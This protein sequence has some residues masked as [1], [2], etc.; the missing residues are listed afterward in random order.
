LTWHNR[1]QQLNRTITQPQPAKFHFIMTFRGFLSGGAI[2]VALAF[3]VTLPS[4]AAN[5]VNRYSFT[6]NA[7]DAVGGAHGTLLGGATVTGGALVLNGSGA[8]VDLPDGLLSTM[9][10]ATIEIWLTDNGSGTWSRIFDFGNGTSQY[11]F[12]SPQSGGGNLRSAITTTGS[13]QQVNWIGNRLPNGVPT[14]VAWT[15][16]AGTQTA[17]LYV[18]GALVGENLAHSLRPLD[19]GVTVN[20]WI[21]RSQF[22]ADPYLNAAINEFRIY[23]GAMTAAEISASNGSGPDNVP[24]GAVAFGLQPQSQTVP[25]LT[26]VEFTATF[27]GSP[28]VGMQWR[29]NGVNLPA[30]TNSALTVFAALTNQNA[31]YSL[32]LTNSHLGAPY[33]V[34]SSNA[35]LS[36]TPDTTSPT[37]IRAGSKF[38]NEVLV[39]FSEA[40]SPA[41]GTNTANYNLTR[42]GGSLAVAGAR[43]GDSTMEIILTTAP[44]TSGT[45]YT[46]TVNGVRDRSAAANLIAANSQANFIATPFLAV[47]VGTPAVGA[48]MIPVSG[49]YNLT[50][51]GTGIGGTNDQFTFAFADYTNNFDVRVRVASV[52]FASSWTRMGLMARAGLTTNAPYAASFATLGAAAS[53]FSARTTTGGSATINGSFP[54]NYPETWLRLRRTGSVFDGFASLDGQSW[55]YLGSA[56][57]AMPSIA[58]V[59]FA[60]T[61]GNATGATSTEIRDFANASG[62]ITTNAALAFEPLGPSSRRTALI[63]SEIMYNPPENWPGGDDL[64]F[65]ELWNSGLVTEDLTGHQLT[66]EIS[67]QF[68]D[69]TTIA[70][71]Q[72]LVVAKDPAAA[73]AF[74]GVNFLGPYAQR[75]SNTGGELFLLNEL[76]G[77]L[78]GIEYDTEA[79]WPVAPDGTGHSLVLSRPSYGENDPR[80]WAASDVK[81]GSPG[82]FESRGNEP[83]RAVV[84]NEFLAH[85][86]APQQDYIELFNPGAQPVNLSGAWLSDDAG[87]NKFRITDGTT[88]PARGFLA[89]NQTQLGFALAADGEKIFLVNSNQTRVLDAVSFDG[90]QNGVSAGRYPNGAPGFQPLSTVTLGTSN[91]PPRLN[92]LTI[93]EIMYHPISGADDDEYLEIH[94]RGPGAVT[95]GG[96][97]IQGG[98][99]FTFP[100]NAV[101]AP[102]GYV[103]AAK[104]LTNLLA[105]YPQL[106]LT[107]AFGNYSGALA[108]SGERLALTMPDD[109]VSTNAQGGVISNIFYIT[110]DEV[111]YSD[112]GRWGKWSDGGGSSL[113]LID[114]DADNRLAPNWADSD[115]SNKATWTTIDVTSILENG[116]TGGLGIPNRFEFFLQG[117]GEAIVD[118]LEF[119]NN[120][121]ANLVANG[122]FNSGAAGWTF[123]G[124]VRNSF[125]QAGVGIGGSQALHV[126]AAARG[127]TGANKAHTALTATATT[128]GANTGTIR[129]SVRWLKGS[130]YIMFRTRGHWMEVSQR[131]NV[132][133]NC[134]TP[135]LPNSKAL[136]N[137]GPAITDVAHTPVLPAAGQP[138]VVTARANDPDGVNLGFLVLNYRL[139]PATI[140][141][142]APMYDHGVGVDAIAGDGIFSGTI[143]AQAAD[144]LAAFYISA[145]DTGSATSKFPTEAPARECLVRWG[146]SVRAGTIGNYR[147]WMTSSNVT[148]WTNREKNAND[149]MDATFVYGNQRV[150]YNVD[151][152]YSGSPW[153]SPNYNG[154][155]GGFAC[156]YEI[157]F[158]P[159]ERFLG[160]EPFVLSAFVVSG[161]FFHNDLTAQVDLTGNWIA[162]K[163]GQPHNY[164]RHIHMFF[165]GLAR[166]TIYDDV[167]Q[168]NGEF[169]EEYFPGDDEGQLRKIEDWFEFANDGQQQNI[170]TATL[171]RVN[172]SDGDID[173]KR[174]RW[175]WRPRA[176]RNPDDWSP[177][178]SLVATVNDTA[179]PDYL[180]RLKSWMDLPNFLRPI[181][182]HHIVGD[183]DSYGYERGKNMYAYKPGAAPWRLLM[184]DIELALGYDSRPATDSIYSIHDTTLRNMILNNP[185]V[186][187]E[188]LKGFHEAV[189]SSLLP[190]AA[191]VLL[192]ERYASFQ[193]NGVPMQGPQTIKNYLAAR[194]AYLLTVLPD[195]AFAVNNP[196]YQ[197][198][199]GSNVLALTGSAPLNVRSILVNGNPYAVTW[200]SVTGWRVLVP[201]GSGTNILAI[202][203][204]DQQG[205][206]ISNATGNVTANYTGPNVA[207]EGVVVFNEIMFRPATPGAAFVELFNTH[208]NYTF[209]LSGWNVNGLGYDFPAGATLAPRSYLVLAENPFIHGQTYGLTN[210]AFAQYPGTLDDDG[211]ALTLFRPGSGTNQ[212]VVDRVRYEPNAPWPA[213]TNGVSLQLVD[214]AQDNSRVANW[215]L[216]S[217]PANPPPSPLALMGYSKVW[218]YNQTANL[219]GVNWTS[220]AYNDAAWPAGAGL[221][222]FDNNAEITPLTGTVLA[223]PRTG[224]GL[225]PGHAYYFRT[226][227]V[228]S[229][230][231]AGYTFTA[232]ARIDDGAVFYVNGAEVRRVRMNASATITNRSL[233]TGAPPNASDATAD[234][235][236][237]IPA[238]A[239]TLGTNVIAASVHQ[240]A[241]NS[242]DIVFGLQLNAV[243]V[244]TAPATPGFANNVTTTL[245]PFPPLWLN[246]LQANNVTGPFDN[247]GQRDPWLEVF[248]TANTN[249]SLSGYYL[250]D[251]YT[252]LTK[253]PFPGSATASNGFT[254]VWSDNQTNQTAA[255]SLHAGILLTP[256]SGRVALTR[257]INNVTQVVDYLNYNNLSANWSYG[258]VPDAQP[259]YRRSMFYATPSATNSGVSAPIEVYINE[260]LADNGGN[261]TD[262]ADGNFEDWFELYN[263]GP[264]PADLGGYYLTD[265]LGDPLK[266]QIPN[267]GHYVVPAGGYLLVWADNES[268]QNSTNRADLH[269]DFALSRSGEALGLFAAD[270]TAIDVIT[271]GSQTTDV[272]E[273]RFPDGAA[274]IFAMPI[275]T[276]RAANIVPNTAPTLAP[277]TNRFLTLG[278]TLNLTAVGADSD[279][280]AQS[281]NY[282]LTAA[283]LG[284]N[285]GAVSG[286]LTWIPAT[287]PSTNQFTVVVADNGTPSLSAT[288][289]FTVIVVLPPTLAGATLNGSEL[290]LSWW[291]VPGQL[292]QVAY[293]DDL[294]DPEWEP[295][296]SAL[297]GTG[298]QLSIT[299]NLSSS[300]QRFYRLIMS[301]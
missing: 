147:L 13:E 212:I 58:Q 61:A 138:V 178:T 254:L 64:E 295:L 109:L 159:D 97:R 37:L 48:T 66:G 188:Y 86:D 263:P 7:D 59:G 268:A 12:V 62:T 231:P 292:Y 139:D 114:P 300:P 46:L 200:T 9:E 196:A 118:D 148:F 165:N 106:N 38:P 81:G 44:Q 229:N 115:E 40:V 84:I 122:T 236:F 57:I 137:A 10:S 1:R 176:T 202:T 163:L 252:N 194:R 251:T 170:V 98:I 247:F 217:T 2:S 75:L 248:N 110:V 227:V 205:N 56:T 262:P 123:N 257:V 15:V 160:S 87:T 249:I 27:A 22:G 177:F 102:G 164:R 289:S 265:N 125:A 198:V 201:L 181:I 14:H 297:A 225:T 270:G 134:G 256:G 53:H 169:L 218:R 233:A 112:G 296:G 290:T 222:A 128:G 20:N 211:E 71:G 107:N 293:K 30:Q 207:P 240:A 73:Q 65:I 92:Q 214:A 116:H 99:S 68:P 43:F 108:N 126:V 232:G 101:I 264:N 34:T 31:A 18:N 272:T 189:H 130:P 172:K 226:T 33:S 103:V 216:A 242:S 208:S 28:P 150:I 52:T 234:D 173:S 104:N 197:V 90:Q 285:I 299:N 253:W 17:R 5:L 11:L 42:V 246:E 187:R 238:F 3:F 67:Y 179:S 185:E 89:Y 72:F 281:L 174:Y 16:D 168:P 78:L 88:I 60:L 143:P 153:H 21:G 277:I 151:T 301:Q 120:G 259:F 224:A 132:P 69:G 158:N 146:E 239:F 280:P 203:A 219:D 161:G 8:Y 186:E 271:F 19:L 100:T 149:T 260:W 184:W 76:G 282:S 258:S 113:E 267:N 45:N 193:Q 286:T 39:T 41:T 119:R 190:G 79:P 298:G 274:N 261:L 284:A 141:S 82:N 124:V 55:E 228:L 145:T 105:K 195:A 135:G 223:D 294:N 70:P 210:V 74:Y 154:P 175:T 142:Q 133:D 245:P 35:V 95:L 155:A 276:P 80:A 287:A 167:Q 144:T 241:T 215:T 183:W 4:S 51:S 96:W 209:D 156:D 191:D 237:V 269:V 283:P 291:S 250:T 243:Y 152:M 171:T 136:A 129:A 235:V 36:I 91:T 94:N 54:V 220:P 93:N 204:T 127:D 63:I 255:G 29:R 166:G 25:E 121:G 50:G 24:F 199:A 83:A 279:V 288:Q 6:A 111:T 117:A 162:R 47:S 49:G 140:Y 77:H 278:Q 213:P 275:T 32:V 206:V 182:T 221:L 266:F 180:N 244:G 230:N 85:T 273:G 131:L 23:N 192:D 26:T 157:N